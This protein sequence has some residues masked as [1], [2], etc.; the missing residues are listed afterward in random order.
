MEGNFKNGQQNNGQQNNQKGNNNGVAPVSNNNSFGKSG[1]KWIAAGL[2]LASV[3]YVV[4]RVCKK[5]I[6]K[7]AGK[8]TEAP[9]APATNE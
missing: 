9:E 4:Y 7:K 8:K 6:G 3:A 1:A 2:G 5:Y